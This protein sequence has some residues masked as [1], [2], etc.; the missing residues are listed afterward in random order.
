MPMIDEA[1]ISNLHKKVILTMRHILQGSLFQN[2]S[3]K[4]RSRNEMR[5]YATISYDVGN[6]NVSIG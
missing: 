2:D 6:T 3:E 4:G 1:D 5:I